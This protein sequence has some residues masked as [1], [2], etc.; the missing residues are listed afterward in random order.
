MS[1]Y[2]K[3]NSPICLGVQNCFESDD[4]CLYTWK[5]ALQ[6]KDDNGVAMISTLNNIVKYQCL[7]NLAKQVGMSKDELFTAMSEPN[8]SNENLLKNIVKALGLSMHH[9]DT[10]VP[11]DTVLSENDNSNDIMV[12]D[13]EINKAAS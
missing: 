4:E 1:E 13:A 9:N 6:E 12:S 11:N 8:P 5:L 7:N 2:N 3:V 10:V